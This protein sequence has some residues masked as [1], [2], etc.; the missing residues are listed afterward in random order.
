MDPYL[1][2]AR[3]RA[4]FHQ[5]LLYNIRAQFRLRDSEESV[6]TVIELLRPK[7]KEGGA[8]QRE[9]RA[10]QARLLESEASLLELDLL[11]GGQDVLAV[12]RGLLSR[13]G[14]S[15][16]AACLH[17]AGAGPLFGCWPISLRDT[18]PESVAVPLTADIGEV[19]LDLAAAFAQTYEDGAYRRRIHYQA[20]P[21]PPLSPEDSAWAEALLSE[22][23]GSDEG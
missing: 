18:L 22:F 6:V 3:L 14:R 20:P 8:G 21:N 1:E 5:A 16:F 9:Y 23:R 12:P 19:A 4:D 10:R 17:R 11:R 2:D 15:D 7:N 13:R